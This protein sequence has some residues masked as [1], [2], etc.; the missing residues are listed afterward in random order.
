MVGNFHGIADI[1][2]VDTASKMMIAC[3]W[4]TAIDKYIY[5]HYIN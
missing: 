1:I 3:A 5:I 4:N 2:P